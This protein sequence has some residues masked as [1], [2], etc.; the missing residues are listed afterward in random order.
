MITLV[1]TIVIIAMVAGTGAGLLLGRGHGPVW[2]LLGGAV[3]GMAGYYIGRIPGRLQIRHERTNLAALSVE[4]LKVELHDLSKG[5][6]GRFT[7][8][9]LLME[10]I[11]RGQDVTEHLGLVLN[12]LEA[13]GEFSRA[14]GFGA[15]LS[16]YPDLAGQL[17]WYNPAQSAVECR[18]KV[19][20]LR[21]V[22]ERGAAPPPRA[23]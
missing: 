7:P 10:L 23:S 15:L 16:A 6:L 14:L 17:R 2:T 9:F 1:D 4:E 11:V 20:E 12:L 3:G 22:V 5:R 18:K 13:E 19:A 8:N 21:K